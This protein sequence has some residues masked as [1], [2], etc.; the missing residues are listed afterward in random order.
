MINRVRLLITL[1]C[2][3]TFFIGENAYTRSTVC[4]NPMVETE[5]NSLPAN[6]SGQSWV[7]DNST[8][9]GP[10][11]YHTYHKKRSALI[12]WTDRELFR[13]MTKG[14]RTEAVMIKKISILQTGRQLEL[15]DYVGNKKRCC[16]FSELPILALAQAS[17]PFSRGMEYVTRID[18][19]YGIRIKLEID[20]LKKTMAGKP[21]LLK[22]PVEKLYVYLTPG[23]EEMILYGKAGSFLF[24]IP[25]KRHCQKVRFQIR[26]GDERHEIIVTF[27]NHKKPV[28]FAE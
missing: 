4:S 10:L 24:D 23:Q 2:F 5:N 22:Y 11:T 12:H 20:H 17:G 14:N 6:F 9:I 7:L 1:L 28:V 27:F 3:F 15:Y 26:S 18:R 19:R 16:N 25:R 13:F 8:A 21:R